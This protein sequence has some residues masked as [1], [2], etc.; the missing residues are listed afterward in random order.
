MKKIYVTVVSLL[1]ICCFTNCGKSSAKLVKAEIPWQLKDISMYDENQGWALTNENEI[2]F[3]DSGIDNFSPVWKLEGVSAAADYFVDVC[4]ADMQNVYASYL[5]ENGDLTVEY[6]KDGGKNWKQTLVK[7][8]DGMLE[9]GGSAYI[10]FSDAENGYLL[11][12]SSPAAGLMTKVLFSTTDA[13]ESFSCM[14]ELSEISGYPQGL[15]VS[16]EKSYIAVSPRS[17]EQYLYVRKDDADQWTSEEI[18]P[19]PEKARYMDGL[20]PVFCMEHGQDGMMVLK[21]VGDDVHYLLLVTKDGGENWQQKEE[22]PLNPVKAYS[23]VNDSR[24]YLVDG[25]GALYQYFSGM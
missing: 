8:E 21:A 7:W 17:K 19:L 9:G 5:S 2:L 3:T 18:I 24:I 15:T 12:C 13:G 6:T 11:Y 23:Y 20:A 1:L 4:F 14:G 25:T 10:S 22:I 16:G